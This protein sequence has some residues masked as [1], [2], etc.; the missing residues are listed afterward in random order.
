MSNFT[1]YTCAV[2]A[3]VIGACIIGAFDRDYDANLMQRLAL[4]AFAFWSLWRVELIWRYDVGWA[5][6]PLLVT[7]LLLYALGS[8]LKTIKWKK[9]K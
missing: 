5:H 7:A 9:R 6:E 8:I 4:G 1:L 3:F 2:Y